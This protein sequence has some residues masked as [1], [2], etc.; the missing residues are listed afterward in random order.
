MTVK[1]EQDQIVKI[2]CQEINKILDFSI[3]LDEN[4]DFK[5][6]VDETG[7]VSFEIKEKVAKKAR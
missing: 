2:L 3:L 6:W 1:L 7:E 4:S 5:F